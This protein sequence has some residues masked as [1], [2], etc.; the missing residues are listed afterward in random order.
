M[1]QLPEFKRRSREQVMRFVREVFGGS[2][3]MHASHLVDLI[4]HQ[5]MHYRVLFKSTYFILPAGQ[6]EPSKSQW[7]TL[8]KKLKRHDRDVFVFKDH[9]TVKTPEGT[10]YYLDFGFFAEFRQSLY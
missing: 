2:A 8:K 10:N 6:T 5:D 9:G 7:N 3:A 4:E 1:K